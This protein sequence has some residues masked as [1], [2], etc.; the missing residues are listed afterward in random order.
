MPPAS[1]T[2]SSSD[3]RRS[4]TSWSTAA[5]TN[6]LVTLPTRKRSVGADV[7]GGVDAVVREH[8][9]ARDAGAREIA[10]RVVAGRGRRGQVAHGERQGEKETH[11]HHLG[12]RLGRTM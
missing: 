12:C 6:V 3:R 1:G 9:G 11:A 2:G 8:D 4:A 5:A 7:A 10:R